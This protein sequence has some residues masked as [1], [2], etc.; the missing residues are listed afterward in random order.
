MLWVLPV[1][2]LQEDAAGGEPGSGRGSRPPAPAGRVP[3]AFVKSSTAPGLS[4]SSFCATSMSDSR[5]LRSSVWNCSERKRARPPS[6][7]RARPE[8][9]ARGRTT[10]PSTQERQGPGCREG[11]GR[12]GRRCGGLSTGQGTGSVGTGHVVTSRTLYPTSQV[13][14]PQSLRRLRAPL[15]LPGDRL[16]PQAER[17]ASHARLAGGTTGRQRLWQPAR[18]P[19]KDGGV[20]GTGSQTPYPLAPSTAAASAIT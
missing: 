11:R 19:D 1:S 18:P 20:L 12:G 14:G 16:A 15:R 9:Q 8:H 7:R 5:I 4:A 6:A 3:F 2:V 10:L 13:S 17:R